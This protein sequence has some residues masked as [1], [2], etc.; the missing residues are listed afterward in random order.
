LPHNLQRLPLSQSSDNDRLRRQTGAKP[1]DLQ[2]LPLSQRFD[3]GNWRC[4]IVAKSA[5]P[6]NQA[7]LSLDSLGSDI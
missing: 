2:R 1:L 4:Q 7:D 6:R 3:N 5:N